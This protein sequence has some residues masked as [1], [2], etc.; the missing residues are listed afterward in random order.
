MSMS[1]FSIMGES[2]FA[3]G[4]TKLEFLPF[5]NPTV[6]VF[7]SDSAGG[8]GSIKLGADEPKK[9]VYVIVESEPSWGRYNVSVGLGGVDKNRGTPEG[10]Q[11][12]LFKRVKYH[13]YRPPSMMKEWDKAILICDWE[14]DIRNRAKEFG[15]VSE[16]KRR[17]KIEEAMK[18]EV[19]LLEKMLHEKLMEFNEEF[20]SLR[21]HRNADPKRFSSFMPNPDNER[22][23]Y[24]IGVV[25]EAVRKFIPKYDVPPKRPT[26]R[27][28]IKDLIKA[29]LLSVGETVHGSFDSKAIILDKKGNAKVVEFSKNTKKALKKDLEKLEGIS[30]FKAGS[31]ILKENG[32]TGSSGPA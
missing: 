9:G 15:S 16:K 6:L 28:H 26:T 5:Y 21:V 24:Y 4:F 12:T 1:A 30:L 3:P 32:R 11:Q 13:D 25:M 23:E 2:P 22:Y 18:S 20:G 31:A 29:Q 27:K 14:G 8:I 10:K 17:E 19:H 7:D